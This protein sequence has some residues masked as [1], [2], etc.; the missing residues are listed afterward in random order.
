MNCAFQ[1]LS[2]EKSRGQRAPA[3][4]D[5]GRNSTAGMSV[6]NEG[7]TMRN[8]ISR[9]ST[10]RK[11]QSTADSHMPHNGNVLP[12]QRVGFAP[13]DVA[14]GQ[15][16]ILQGVFGRLKS[17]AKEMARITGDSERACRNQLAGLNSMQLHKFFRACQ[18]IPE[19]QAWGAYMMGLS[20]ANPKFQQEMTRGYREI[21]LRID[22]NGLTFGKDADG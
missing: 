5:M 20:P 3:K 7:A 11:I 21:L 13:D 16:E 8:H 15:A 19:V 17:P 6:H 18:T 14:K 10:P 9:L 1:N 22:A 4:L 12:K 2:R